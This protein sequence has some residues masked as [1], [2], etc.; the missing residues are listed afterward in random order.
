MSE[1]LKFKKTFQRNSEDEV[2][3]VVEI[4]WIEKKKKTNL[5]SLDEEYIE[6]IFASKLKNKKDLLNIINSITKFLL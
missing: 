1:L 6:D 3:Y 5:A 4:D 2:L